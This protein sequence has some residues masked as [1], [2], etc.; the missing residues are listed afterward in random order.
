MPM[1]QNSPLTPVQIGP[2]NRPLSPL[3]LGSFIFGADAW[4]TAAQAQLNA[5]MQAALDQKARE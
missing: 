5:T 2:A 3:A 4:G 1:M